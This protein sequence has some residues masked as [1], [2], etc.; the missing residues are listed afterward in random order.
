MRVGMNPLRDERMAVSD[1]PVI[2]V[3]VHLP[4][5]QDYH[6]SRFEIVTASLTLARQSAGTD[7]HFLIWDNG[8]SPKMRE[9][10]LDFAPDTLILS[11][12]VGVL[13]AM[14][15]IYHAFRDS[16]IAWCNDDILYYPNWLAPQLE[17]LEAFPNVGTVS[18]CVTRYYSC[19]AD[20]HTIEWAR[21]YGR[22]SAVN[23]P[24]QWDMQHGISVGRGANEAASVFV[25]AVIP[26]VEYKGH[27][28]LIGGGHCQF[29]SRAETIIPFLHETDRYMHPLY[30]TLDESIDS[31]GYLR[32]MT[33]NRLT[34]HLGNVLTDEDR[35][36]IHELVGTVNA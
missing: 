14:T 25:N 23:T 21:K 2:A 7:H 15:R 22:V 19:K 28:A 20:Q 24:S 16:V 5:E 3:L 10:L 9:W 31:A 34:R 17:L 12:N 6:V 8:S 32:L 4:H 36:E 1:L 33:P 30:K 27:T 35:K 11:H 29:V 26:S 13:N 18:G